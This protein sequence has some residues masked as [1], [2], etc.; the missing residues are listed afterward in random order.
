MNEFIR[1]TT[2]YV[3][4]PDY[5]QKL[6]NVVLQKDLHD[7]EELCPYCHGTGMTITNNSY[8]LSED[9]DRSR[10]HF[11][12]KHQSI[13]F[14]QH[15]WNGVIKRCPHCGSLMERGYCSCKESQRA[16]YLDEAR[17][18]QEAMDNAPIAPKEELDKVECF[19]SESYGGND[20]YFFDW[21]EFFEY[22]FENST[23]DS[24]R[25]EYVWI[26]EPVRM[27]IDAQNIIE[28]ATDDLYEDASQD[29]SD[30][31]RKELQDFLDDWCRRC[32]VGT[33]Y[34]ESHK[35]KVRIPWEEYDNNGG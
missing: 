12:Y 27:S 1:P 33:T 7:N 3:K 26:T 13:T 21:E 23:P 32:G 14:C 19:Y 25:P 22:W 35:Y 8:G 28:Q 5:I 18:K 31:E 6:V 10:G 16:K 9:P 20:G 11:P 29:V 34:F 15:C 24:V 30:K 2:N 4:D 17:K